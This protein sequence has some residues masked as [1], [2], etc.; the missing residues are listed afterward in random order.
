MMR[1]RDTYICS[2]KLPNARIHEARVARPTAHEKHVS[3]PSLCDL[4]AHLEH[5]RTKNAGTTYARRWIWGGG[6]IIHLAGNKIK[7]LAM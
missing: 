6:N 4:L 3:T 2:W 5:Q 7:T 1:N